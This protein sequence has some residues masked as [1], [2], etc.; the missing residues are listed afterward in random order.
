MA[1]KAEVVYK[2]HVGLT[3]R[4]SPEQ[5]RVTIEGAAVKVLYPFP[6]EEY[7]EAEA[8][9][10]FKRVKAH[11]ERRDMATRNMRPEDAEKAEKDIVFERREPRVK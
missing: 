4:H 10:E 6:G 3:L 8:Q 9:A 5:E 2:T 11:Y 7:N 1:T